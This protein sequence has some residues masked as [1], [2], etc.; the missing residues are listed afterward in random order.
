MRMILRLY[1]S[2]CLT[3]LLAFYTLSP[4]QTDSTWLLRRYRTGEKVVYRMSATNRGKESATRYDVRAAGEVKR[5]SAG[6]FFEELAWSDLSVNG[7]RVALS[8]ASLKFRERLSLS[9]SYRLAIPDLSRIHPGLVGPVV[10]LL[11][12]YADV[13]IAS[14]EPG[15]AQPGDH[16]YVNDGSPNSWADGSRVLVGED[17]I[18]FDLTLSDVSYTDSV[19]TLVVRHV[20]PARPAITLAAPWM[21]VPVGE[22]PNNW[23][24]VARGDSGRYV[25]SVGNETFVA[26]IR[27]NLKD[28]SVLSATLDNGV[29]VL[30]KR[31]RD[32][33]LTLC[34]DPVRYQIRR[35][36]EI[37]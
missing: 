14:R 3:A 30:E 11:T 7:T 16:V 34:E 18:D 28:G 5:D 19:A 32:S 27:I 12:F 36:I 21:R 37:H 23:V 25:A 26:S 22:T 24:Q 33:L 4:A 9:P 1:P 17:A 6:V 8:P 29:D 13:Q 15:L 35:R 10:D 2:A 20:P 31:C